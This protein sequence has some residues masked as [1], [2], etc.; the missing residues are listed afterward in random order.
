MYHSGRT[1]NYQRGEKGLVGSKRGKLR[2]EEEGKEG[3]LYLQMALFLS[4]LLFS[5]VPARLFQRRCKGEGMAK[6]A[7][8]KNVNIFCLHFF[9]KKLSSLLVVQRL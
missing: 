7:A 4:R 6:L 9:G 8:E 1:F 2:K 5:S 3:R